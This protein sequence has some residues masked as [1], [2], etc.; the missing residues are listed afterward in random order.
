MEDPF[1]REHVEGSGFAHIECGRRVEVVG[2]AISKAVLV[3][4]AMLKVVSGLRLWEGPC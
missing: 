2:G 4:R 1:V 3:G